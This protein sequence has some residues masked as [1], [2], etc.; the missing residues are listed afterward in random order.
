MKNV[1]EGIQGFYKNL[2]NP[3]NKSSQAYREWEFGYNKAYF[4]NLERQKKYESERAK[5]KAS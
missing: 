3:H 4:E 1:R 2:T 5:A